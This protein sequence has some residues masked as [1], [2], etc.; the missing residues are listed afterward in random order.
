MCKLAVASPLCRCREGR[1]ALVTS[2]ACF[3]YIAYYAMIQT[4]TV[5]ILYGIDS[6]LADFQVRRGCTSYGDVRRRD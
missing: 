2:F 6:N 3:K 5:T 1:A 4:T